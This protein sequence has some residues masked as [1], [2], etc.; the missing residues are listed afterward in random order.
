LT[1][2]YLI[3][4]AFK[5][6]C[7]HGWQIQKNAITV[8]YIIEQ[9]LY[10]ITGESIKTTGAGRTDAGVHAKFFSLHIDSRHELFKNVSIFLYKIN[11]ILPDDIAVLGLHEVSPDFHARYSALARIYEY[12]LCRVKD[13]F[14]FDFTWR[15]ERD[16]DLNLM[17]EA[18][19]LLCS[20]D[21]F[22]SF[23]KLHSNTKTNYCKVNYACWKEDGSSMVFRI[24][25]DRFLRNMVRAIVGSLIEVGRGKI[26]IMQFREI[27]ESKNRGKAKYSAPAKGLF[28]TSVEYPQNISEIISH[29]NWKIS[30]FPF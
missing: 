15:Y 28:L 17:N 2:R 26:N 30:K 18:A 4:I 3:I 29:N 24:K 14:L 8:Q 23:S 7:Y 20:Y 21:D 27:I 11:S 6:T 5:G 25:A 9:A 12:R 16:L 13:P 19:Y 10:K 1:N 22:T